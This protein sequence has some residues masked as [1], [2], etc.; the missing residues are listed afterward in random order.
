MPGMS[1]SSLG[2]VAAAVTATNTERIV[3][4]VNC[5]AVMWRS[6]GSI[7]CL[8]DADERRKLAEI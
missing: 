3:V 6:A 5:M 8:G 2:M 1:K 4:I 7:A